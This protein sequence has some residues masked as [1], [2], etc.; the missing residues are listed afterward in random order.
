MNRLTLA[1]RGVALAAVLVTACASSSQP[2]VLT[3]L[4][5]PDQ[6]QTVKP[7]GTGLQLAM[8]GEP[9]VERAED[10]DLDG[11]SVAI[12][13]G[14][15]IAGNVAMFMFEVM[16]PENGHAQVSA[17]EERPG[18]PEDSHV[19]TER[20]FHAGG[21]PIVDLV[22]D[23]PELGAA[24]YYR[25]IHGRTRVYMIGMRMPLA[26]EQYLQPF[27]EEYFGSLEV[28]PA[29]A[30]SPT[31]TGEVAMEGWHYIYPPEAGFAVD[32]PGD[33]SAQHTTHEWEGEDLPVQTYGVRRDD[34][35]AFQVRA[36]T[37]GERPPA[38]VFDTA[39]TRAEES[40]F[41]VRDEHDM[42]R[43]GYAGRTVLYESAERFLEVRYYL[44][45]ARLYEVW[46]S[47]PKN[48]GSGLD[49]ARDRFFR[50]FRIL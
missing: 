24:T 27:V 11:T 30:P 20:G 32:V 2:G 36:T 45:N 34:G 49:P 33:A 41:S 25:I 6:W 1:S 10:L 5:A 47:T 48:Q 22:V 12:T 4:T 16:A 8:P 18:T 46:V 31:G 17:V 23:H 9:V 13:R 42:D 39:K 44:T 28:D 15:L 50:S 43:Q 29:E 26:A 38:E 40:G 7:A 37:Y 19:R 3:H 21:F 35:L 14:S